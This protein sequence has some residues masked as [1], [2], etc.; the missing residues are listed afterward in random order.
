MKAVMSSARP[1]VYYIDLTH[2]VEP[3]NVLQASFILKT[4]YSYFPRGTVFVCVVDPGVG[5]SRKIIAARTRDY[6]FCAPDN[7]LLYETLQEQKVRSQVAVENA[8]FF[9]KER[10]STFH[11]RDRFAPLAAELLTRKSLSSLGR[12]CKRIQSLLLPQPKVSVSKVT[13][14]VLYSDSFGNLVTS[15]PTYLFEKARR[16]R[17][18]KG[19]IKNKTIDG[20]TVTYVDAP[21]KKMSFIPGSYG[22]IEIF[23]PGGSA[24]RVC[25]AAFGDPCEA[26]FV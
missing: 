14:N 10:S 7:G 4:S 13:G 12:P 9:L 22:M 21:Q 19:K 25:R 26:V 16:G 20:Y 17:T 18:V 8:P 2:S 24:Q 5:T 15:I 23:C 11:G 3:Q 6:T 1:D